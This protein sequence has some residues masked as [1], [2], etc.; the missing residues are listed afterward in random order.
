MKK[1]FVLFACIAALVVLLNAPSA[2]ARNKLVGTWKYVEVIPPGPDAKPTPLHAGLLM[3]TKHH[4]SM[5]FISGAQPRPALPEFGVTP[6][7]LLAAWSPF[8]A[9]SGTYEVK[10]N[11]F[12]AK[13]LVAKN[14]NFMVTD[15][16][17]TS[18]FKIQGKTLITTPKAN[19]SGPINQGSTK[20]IRVE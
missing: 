5:I 17:I 18:E 10:G 12:T 9:T 20:L 3:F 6:Q 13:I 2:S 15:T 19:N 8:A 4:F 16:W 7:Q 11:T 1:Q 14:P